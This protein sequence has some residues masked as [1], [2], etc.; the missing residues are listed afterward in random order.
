MLFV[1]VSP[2]DPFIILLWVLLVLVIGKQYD[3]YR[4]SLVDFANSCHNAGMNNMTPHCCYSCLFSRWWRTT[5]KGRVTRARWLSSSRIQTDLAVPAG[6]W[7]EEGFCP[8]A[9]RW[10]GVSITLHLPPP[11]S[12]YHY[13]FL[14]LILTMDEVD[15]I[16]GAPLLNVS[17]SS[18]KSLLNEC[19]IFQIFYFY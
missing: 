14:E 10:P 17:K 9:S 5:R 4:F 11:P 18:L 13:F 7:S 8:P 2:A 16:T 15:D 12:V 6:L 3:L 1:T 19:Q